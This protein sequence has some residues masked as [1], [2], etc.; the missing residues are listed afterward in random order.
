MKK[1]IL[2][3]SVALFSIGLFAQTNTDNLP[4]TAQDFIKENF[5]SVSVAEV[6][7]NSSWQIWE[8]DKYEVSLSNGIELDFNKNGEIIEID[9]QNDE[10]IPQSTLPS[11]IATYL[12][13]NYPDAQVIGWEK[14]DK[15]QEV[16]LADGTELE[17][18]GQ[19]NFRRID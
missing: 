7:E 18:D 14:Q 9:S 4:S 17:F 3:A 5:S 1:V 16:E 13:E 19:G 8:D 12:Q 11:N 6:K 15:K 2:S 10:S